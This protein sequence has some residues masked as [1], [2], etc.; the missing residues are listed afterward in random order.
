MFASEPPSSVSNWDLSPI[1]DTIQRPT[2]SLASFSKLFRANPHGSEKRQ[3]KQYGGDGAD[4]QPTNPEH[5]HVNP[6]LGDL[7]VLWSMIDFES[8]S[9]R[10]I[11]HEEVTSDTLMGSELPQNHLSTL[12]TLQQSHEDGTPREKSHTETTRPLPGA[13]PEPEIPGMEAIQRNNTRTSRSTSHLPAWTI[14]QR[15]RAKPNKT[16]LTEYPPPH[17]ILKSRI[18][19]DAPTLKAKLRP[20]TKLA[21]KTE[22]LFPENR[23]ELNSE[24]KT[25]ISDPPR[26]SRSGAF[27]LVPSQVVIPEAHITQYDMPPSSC[28]EKDWNLNPDTIRNV[29][30][31]S[32]PIL[33][34]SNKYKDAAERHVFLM[35]KLLRD[36]PEYAQL[37]SQVGRPQRLGAGVE[38]QIIHV[39]VD[40]SNVC[41]KYRFA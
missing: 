19:L 28:E 4:S 8:T 38:S 32:K 7:S 34:E 27:G 20:N 1:I 24:T 36:F 18:Q 3:P 14:L 25:I 2:V 39:F 31:C 16:G 12:A 17:T 13:V 15:A 9:S 11:A 37:V 22:P 5:Q 21:T 6:K 41:P 26:P 40:M 23:A 33:V 30:H 35:T 29:I 10:G